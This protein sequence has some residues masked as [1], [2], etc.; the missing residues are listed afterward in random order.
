MKRILVITLVA[1]LCW[2]T[3][4]EAGTLHAQVVEIHD[5]RTITVVNMGRRLKIILKA[6]DAPE[7]DQPYADIAR[8]HL[9]DLILGK[10]VIVEYTE[11][12]SGSVLVARVF[13]NEMDVGQQMVRDGVAWYDSTY[14]KE[15]GQLSSRLYAES[16]QAARS[17]RRGIWQDTSPIPPW[18]WRQARAARQDRG[19][20]AIP[21]STPTS[22]KATPQTA[23]ATSPVKETRALNSAP[24]TGEAERLV[25][26]LFALGGEEFAVRIPSGGRQFPLEIEVPQGES[27]QANYYF[28]SHP[29]IKYVAFWASGPNQGQAVSSFF[30]QAFAGFQYGFERSF[31]AKGLPFSCKL[32]EGKDITLN[33]Y[34]GRRYKLDGCFL[35]GGARL[36]YKTEGK[37]MKL[38]LV[39]ITSEI[40]GDPAVEQFLESFSIRK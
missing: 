1:M 13:C 15:L 18:E 31:E 27:V 24:L 30:E 29:R 11:L 40:P 17:E 36:Y 6:A 10:Q 34:T 14:D 23:V 5:G 33:G 8:Q 32:A 4:V 38:Y 37:R 25:W 39:G 20:H 16:E 2:P 28:V 22:P 21:S 19:V 35:N 9:A 26:P 12:A 3:L 7:G